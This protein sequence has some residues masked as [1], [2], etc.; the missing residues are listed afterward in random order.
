MDI[1]TLLP[2]SGETMKL[3]AIAALLHAIAFLMDYEAIFPKTYYTDKLY[4]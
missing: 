1:E 3:I 2:R 4:E